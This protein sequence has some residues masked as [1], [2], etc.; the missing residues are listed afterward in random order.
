MPPCHRLT[1]PSF[2]SP[3][4]QVRHHEGTFAELRAAGA[5]GEGPAYADADTAAQAL[6][7]AAPVGVTHYRLERLV[8]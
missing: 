2:F 8:L 4:L 6:M 3:S 5:P 1:S 7:A